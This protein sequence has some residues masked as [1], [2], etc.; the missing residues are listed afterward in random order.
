MKPVLK[1]AFV[2]VAIAL[3]YPVPRLLGQEPTEYEVKAAFLYNFA[4]FVEWQ[5]NAFNGHP[6][7][8]VIGVLGKDPFGEILER[9]INN[10]SV[11]ERK[12]AIRRFRS[13]ENPSD[14]QILFISSS[15]KNNL[16]AILKRLEG[17]NVLTVGDVEKFA[18]SG[19]II[20]LVLVE[21]KVHF[22]VNVTAAERAK[23]KL[24]SRML[25]LAKIIKG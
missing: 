5:P 2:V 24:S 15:E 17:S 6:Q 10:K 19:G 11:N 13:N 1:A 23:V 12:L 25:K 8:I 22:E 3:L 7:T 4:K 20:D 18:E 21:G 14:C 9:T 16:P